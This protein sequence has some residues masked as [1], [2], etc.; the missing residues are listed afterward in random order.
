MAWT[1]DISLVEGVII[2]SRSQPFFIC[3]VCVRCSFPVRQG[4][5]VVKKPKWDRFRTSK[6]TCSMNSDEF[7]IYIDL[8]Y[9]SF[10]PIQLLSL[11]GACELCLVWVVQNS[12]HQ[13]RWFQVRVA[14]RLLSVWTHDR[15]MI[16]YHLAN[17]W[18][19]PYSKGT[20]SHP[21][22]DFRTWQPVHVWLRS[23][24]FTLIFAWRHAPIHVQIPSNDQGYSG[25]A[26]VP[27]II[28][29][30]A[31]PG[32]PGITLGICLLGNIVVTSD[33]HTISI[34]GK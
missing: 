1:S 23:L 11:M 29:P 31:R 32:L 14:Q 30:K 28:G 13:S 27:F 34:V 15:Y 4:S 18:V 17:L 20:S 33:N 26:L 9:C 16:P 2:F 24:P 8:S 12:Q 22:Y 21:E 10:R 19:H 25:S 5:G 3:R 6:A 7:M